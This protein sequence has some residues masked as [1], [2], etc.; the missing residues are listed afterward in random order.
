VKS[1]I[2]RGDQ[3]AEFYARKADQLRRAV[4][5]RARGLD[6]MLIDDACAYAWEKLLRRPD[7]DV[8][9][10]DAYRWIYTV[11]LRQA[12]ALSRGQHRAQ[13]AG[14]LSGTDDE[15]SEPPSR[16]RDLVDVVADRVDHAI[17]REVLLTLHWRERRELLLYAHGLSYDEIAEVTGT[18][19]TAVNRWLARG[20]NALRQARARRDGIDDLDAPR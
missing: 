7:I 9:R 4:T 14:G 1:A 5:A 2:A 19:R 6:P 18:S 20:K 15:Q 10:H 8:T 11:A 13:P 3:I 17:V 12:W 16:D